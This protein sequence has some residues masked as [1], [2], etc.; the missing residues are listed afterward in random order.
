VVDEEGN[1]IFAIGSDGHV[2]GNYVLDPSNAK[3]S[4][5]SSS[6]HNSESVYIGPARISYTGG[7]LRFYN[8]KNT[9]PTILQGN[10]YNVSSIPAA[11]SG[12]DE[13]IHEWM[14]V[15]RTLASD[16]T[17]TVS[18]VFPAANLAADFDEVEYAESDDVYT[19]AEVDQDVATLET[20]IAA[21][22]DNL[23]AAQLIVCNGDVFESD[24]YTDT[25][26][27]TTLLAAKQDDLSAAQLTV[28]NGDVFES[29]DYTATSALTTLLAAKQ[30]DLSAAQLTV[31]NG[32]VFE[33]DD[34]TATSALTTLL[35]AKQDDLSAAQLTVCNGD[36]FESDD[37]TATSSL[38]TLLAAKAIQTAVDAANGIQD[39]AI[40]LKANLTGNTF[41][42][43]TVL[44]PSTNTMIPL[45]INNYF[46][47]QYA[48]DIY[49]HNH[50]VRVMSKTTNS[51]TSIFEVRTNN[52]NNVE[53]K[54]KGNGETEIST[55]KTTGN[56][57]FFDTTPVAQQSTTG[58]VL[59]GSSGSG[60]TVRVGSTFT[61]NSGSTAYMIGDIVLALKNLGLLAL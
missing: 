55:L 2:L 28:C 54:V 1:L 42:G 50:G 33:S 15:A 39:T 41:T 17:V 4:Y 40:A 34:Y 59:G 14:H 16:N 27:L 38:T 48:C 18:S 20:S 6:V 44:Q 24:D 11:V 7:K 51:N 52:Y 26:A 36:V 29:D 21:K 23:S 30:D 25:S 46:P 47:N 56:V 8:I 19:K 53:L 12:S 37:Y 22:Q 60:G 32:D 10:P 58:T 45:R 49:S 5:N 9:I 3:D 35:A 57:G 43:A 31:C 13:K 61:G